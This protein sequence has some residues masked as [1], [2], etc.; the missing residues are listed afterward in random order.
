MK[1]RRTG[2]CGQV[3]LESGKWYVRYRDSRVINGELKTQKV[4]GPQL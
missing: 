1:K 2:Q 3:Y 4:I